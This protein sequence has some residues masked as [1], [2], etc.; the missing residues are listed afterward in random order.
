MKYQKEDDMT[1]KDFVIKLFTGRSPLKDGYV[2]CGCCEGSGMTPYAS[3]TSA[4]LERCDKC[5]TTGQVK[6]RKS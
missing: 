5:E 2:Y 6:R 4:G 3:G 1:I